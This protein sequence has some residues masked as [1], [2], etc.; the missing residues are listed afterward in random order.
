MATE[1][2]VKVEKVLRFILTCWDGDI[3]ILEGY[4]SVAEIRERIGGLEW[5]IM[6]N[7][8]EIKASAIAKIQP[9]ED[10]RFQK[11]VAWRHKRQQFLRLPSTPGGKATWNDPVHGEIND[12]GVQAISGVIKNLPALPQSTGKGLTEGGK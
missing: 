6:P 4:S 9:Y 3:Y 8:A 5:V 12:A 7:G 2:K 1:E 10:Y 11:D